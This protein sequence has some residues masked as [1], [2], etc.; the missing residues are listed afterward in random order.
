MGWLGRDSSAR[1]TRP[2]TPL[3]SGPGPQGGGGACAMTGVALVARGRFHRGIPDLI[4]LSEVSR[5]RFETASSLFAEVAAFTP[6][7]DGDARLRLK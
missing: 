5:F 2:P 7:G 4:D 3:R 1:T 6:V